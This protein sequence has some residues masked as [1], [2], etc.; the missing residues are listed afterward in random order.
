MYKSTL[1]A[2]GTALAIASA[3]LAPAAL[4]PAVAAPLAQATPAG[5]GIAQ[6]ATER[7]HSRHHRH[8][9]R[10]GRPYRAGFYYSTKCFLTRV[11]VY[12]HR[13][14]RHVWRTREVCRPV[15]IYY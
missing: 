4:T 11:K 3:S 2:F 1:I 15:R 10:H 7:V 13:R 6:S 14:H 8:R 12:S 9:H 5:A